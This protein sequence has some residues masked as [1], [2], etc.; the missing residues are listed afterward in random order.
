MAESTTWT[1]TLRA[2]GYCISGGNA[3][4][5]K[6]WARIWGIDTSHFDAGRARLETLRRINEPRPLAEILVEGSTYSRG[7][8]KRRLYA[9]GIKRRECELCGQSEHWY[10]APMSLILDHVN[11]VRDDNRLENLRIVC[12]N[13]AAT[14]PTHCGRGKRHPAEARL[15]EP[16][17]GSFFPVHPSQTYCS[18]SCSGKGRGEIQRGVP[19]PQTR[20]VERPPYEQ[21]IAEIEATGWSAVGRKYG[22]SDNAVRKWVRWYELGLERSGEAEPS[23]V[24]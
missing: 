22:V 14:L 1:A 19:S 8:L 12:P 24:A 23:D 17:G 5:V 2:L 18:T 20:K 15:C 9:E 21:L 11:G 7:H 16:C 10:G 13:C 3:A 4:T 6:K